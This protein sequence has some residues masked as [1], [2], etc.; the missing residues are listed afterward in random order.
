MKRL[1][2]TLAFI[3]ALGLGL[4]AQAQ[5]W[6]LDKSHSEVGFSVKHM[7]IA[8][9]N[10]VFGEFDGTVSFDPDNLGA[11]KITGVVQVASIDTKNERRDGH[12]RSDDFFNAE[13]YP[14]ITFESTEIK[15]SGDGYV[16]VG[17]LTIRD[18][19]KTVE[20]P[21]TM[22]GPIKDPWG[23]TRIAVDGSATI[24]RQDYNIK[25]NNKM[26]DG[27]LIVSDE[28]VLNLHAEL[29]KK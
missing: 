24:K 29:I 9:V 17:N 20:I 6:E 5:T 1:A 10:G 28:V 13:Q 16:A 7:V 26:D 19:T 12:L 21:F 2:I 11:S 8:T 3:V 27:N 4:T 14:E 18:V 25:W 15:K 23:G 22:A